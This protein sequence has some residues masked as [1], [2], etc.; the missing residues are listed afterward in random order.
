MR[1]LLHLAVL[2]AVALST[3]VAAVQAQGADDVIATIREAAARHGVSADRLVQVARCETGGTF[4]PN[5]VGRLGE[6]GIF[7]LLPVRGLGATFRTMG[8]SDPFNVW[9][10]SDFAAWAFAR[11]MAGH[12]SC[13]R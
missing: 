10:A 2:G 5:A 3:Q 8:Y 13:A 6:Q 4:N 9:E 7:Q 1:R 11:G 12:W